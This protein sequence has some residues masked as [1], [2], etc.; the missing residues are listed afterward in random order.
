MARI[1]YRARVRVDLE[2]TSSST[3]RC[4]MGTA[5]VMRGRFTLTSA[6]ICFFAE[7]NRYRVRVRVE[8]SWQFTRS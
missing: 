7:R 6:A 5:R 3:A 8:L 4:V 2:L 1:K